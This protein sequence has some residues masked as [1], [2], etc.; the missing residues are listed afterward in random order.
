MS[1]I[2]VRDLLIV[3]CEE[4]KMVP[5][6]R[7]SIHNL[8]YQF[9][10]FPR[11]QLHWAKTKFLPPANEVWGMVMFSQ[12]FICPWG[13]GFP[14]C[15]TGHITGKGGCLHRGGGIFIQGVSI[16]GSALGGSASRR[17]LHDPRGVCIQGVGRPPCQDT[18]GCGQRAG[19]THPARMNPRWLVLG[20]AC[21]K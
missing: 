12:V 15:I 13:G 3:G 19:G 9:K 11:V 4:K 21:C 5:C 8:R 18:T 7:Q 10:T 16:Q 6:Y 14:A 20:A 1:V 2:A 17:G